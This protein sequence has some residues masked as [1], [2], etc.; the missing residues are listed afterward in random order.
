MEKIICADAMYQS[1]ALVGCNCAQRFVNLPSGPL[2]VAD[3]HAGRSQTIR[4]NTFQH[5]MIWPTLMDAS[6]R[7]F[8]N[9]INKEN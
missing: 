2:D 1:I 8:K 7:F 6:D 9:M 4:P 3:C 5:R